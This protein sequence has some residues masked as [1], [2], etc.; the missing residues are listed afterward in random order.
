MLR[1]TF[2]LEGRFH[3]QARMKKRLSSPVE[4]A[5]GIWFAGVQATGASRWCVTLKRPCIQ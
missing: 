5:Q 3:E 4:L 2:D 1:I